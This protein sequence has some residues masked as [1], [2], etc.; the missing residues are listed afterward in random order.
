MGSSGQRRAS[1]SL[2]LSAHRG[3]VS[4]LSRGSGRSSTP[5]ADTL[6]AAREGR[7]E[8]VALGA[9]ADLFDP[10]REIDRGAVVSSKRL[11]PDIMRRNGVAIN[12]CNA[13]GSE[14]GTVPGEISA[15]AGAGAGAGTDAGVGAGAGVSGVGRAVAHISQRES[16]LLLRNVHA[17]QLHSCTAAGAGTGAAEDVLAPRLRAG[18]REVWR[19]RLADAWRVRGGG[20]PVQ[21]SISTVHIVLVPSDDFWRHVDSS[22]L[23]AASSSLFGRLSV[24]TSTMISEAPGHEMMRVAVLTSTSAEVSVSQPRRS[25]SISACLPL[26]LVGG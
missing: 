1:C 7:N 14:A 3:S 26:V 8:A 24:S 10:A 18:W 13:G 2:S 11:S 12:A 19:D 5:L 23:C 9:V 22:R 25:T 15:E 17:A 6:D 21:A 4:T 16:K 20:G